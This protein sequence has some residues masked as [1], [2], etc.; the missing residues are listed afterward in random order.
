MHWRAIAALVAMLVALLVASLAFTGKRTETVPPRARLFPELTPADI[1]EIRADVRTGDHSPMTVHARRNGRAWTLLAPVPDEADPQTID[2][3]VHDLARLAYTRRLDGP[4]EAAHGFEP[5]AIAITA[6]CAAGPPIELRLG[7]AASMEAHLYARVEGR[8]D[9]YVV[10]ADLAGH[11]RKEPGAF[12]NKRIVETLPSDAMEVTLTFTGPGSPVM[13][14]RQGDGTWRQVTPVEDRAD[15][16]VVMEFLGRVH[17]HAQAKR[18]VDPVDGRPPT[19]ADHGL[20]PPFLKLEIRNTG[21][22][23]EAVSYG[24]APT[25]WRGQR[26]PGLFACRHRD[27]RILECEPS[28]HL[29]ALRRAAN[30][31]HFR[32]RTL[33]DLPAA[34]LDRITATAPAGAHTWELAREASVWSL[35][36]P[37][38][39]ACFMQ[40]PQRVL[41]QVPLLIASGFVDAMPAEG[42]AALG[43]DA[44]HAWTVTVAAGER[45]ETLR[46]GAETTDGQ[47]YAQRGTVVYTVPAATV[48]ALLGEERG[49]LTFVHR[50]VW[51]IDE[52]PREAVPLSLA[53]TWRDDAGE[54]TQTW[55]RSVG[56]DGTV[57]WRDANGAPAAHGDALTATYDQ[58]RVLHA[59]QWLVDAP[60]DAD[61]RRAGLAEAA[62]PDGWRVR[63]TVT[64]QEPGTAPVTAT[65]WVGREYTESGSQ[66]ASALRHRFRVTPALAS[67]GDMIGTMRDDLAQ[68]LRD[69]RKP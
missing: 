56:P 37:R 3:L 32:E 23:V 21:G 48:R 30:A 67:Q 53:V 11:C 33:V 24:T 64:R 63:A 9:V 5:P 44:D 12:R 35:T 41:D 10:P 19:Y 14:R 52:G 58:L 55:T 6:T 18:F 43:L 15:L 8:P 4:A 17:L 45:T 27:G 39:L 54:A 49:W 47:R 66:G 20:D 60:T 28:E 50:R 22:R 62:G 46:F 59:A 13:L 1:V 34:A 2:T 26:V 57:T 25:E 51:V 69:L 61:L 42:L 7:A 40:Q 36:K 65:L 16:D 29:D 68:N 38:P 31:A